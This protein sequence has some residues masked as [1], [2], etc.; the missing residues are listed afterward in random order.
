MTEPGGVGM[1]KNP[2]GPAGSSAAIIRLRRS[3]SSSLSMI[4]PGAHLE[5]AIWASSAVGKWSAITSWVVM[6]CSLLALG[7]P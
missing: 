2:A 3:P 6:R 7:S 5:A 1:G 4:W